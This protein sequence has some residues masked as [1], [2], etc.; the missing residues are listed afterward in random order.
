MPLLLD[1]GPQLLGARGRCCGSSRRA[2]FQHFRHQGPPS[3]NRETFGRGV[4]AASDARDDCQHLL[5]R[6]AV[7]GLR[8]VPSPRKSRASRRCIAP[9]SS[10]VEQYSRAKRETVPG[11]LH[12]CRSAESSKKLRPFKATPVSPLQPTNLRTR[13]PGILSHFGLEYNTIVHEP[14]PAD[15]PVARARLRCC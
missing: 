14:A 3:R 4:F 5:R 8:R 9:G 11:A 15:A 2:C 10:A 12:L 13:A 1:Q 7:F 6:K